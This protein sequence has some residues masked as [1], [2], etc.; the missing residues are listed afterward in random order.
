MIGSLADRL[1]GYTVV[2]GLIAM[3]LA[4]ALVGAVANL[5]LAVAAMLLCGVGNVM[6]LIPSH[7][8]VQRQTPAALL[9][10]VLS[11]RSTLIFGL[12]IASNAV[13][14]WAGQTFGTRQSLIVCAAW[15]W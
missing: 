2:V 7:T 6:V 15:R 14:G 10:R 1:P 9:G 8:L 11:V 3:G 5:W 12:L 4:I 13:G